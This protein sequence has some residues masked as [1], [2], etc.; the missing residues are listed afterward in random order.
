MYLSKRIKLSLFGF[1]VFGL[2]LI[3]VVIFSDLC[4]L[5]V[6]T[7]NAEPLDDWTEK[8]GLDNAALLKQPIDALAEKLIEKKQIYKVDISYSLPNRIDIKTNNYKPICFVLDKSSNK[9][10]GI[11][12]E[13][14]VVTLKNCQYSWDNPVLTSLSITK[15]FGYCR[16]Y[17]VR[18]VVN[19]L[20]KLQKENLDLYRLIDEI[21]FGNSGFLKV[22]I[23]GLPYR[24]KVRAEHLLVDI[25]KFIAFV[26]KYNPNLENVRLLDLR[27]DEMI[28]CSQGKE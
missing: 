21:D 7:V 19:E 22:S 4:R 25:K 16:D 8:Y 18:L 5:E 13:A 28:V 1:I 3:T 20:V 6:V 12:G 9:I 14:R 10:Y 24:L 27:Y 17:R 15:P 2:T 23:D 26:S 11:N